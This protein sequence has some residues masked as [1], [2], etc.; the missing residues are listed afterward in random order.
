MATEAQLTAAFKLAGFSRGRPSADNQRD[1]LVPNNDQVLAELFTDDVLRGLQVRSGEPRE[2]VENGGESTAVGGTESLAAT[3]IEATLTAG[4]TT[5]GRPFDLESID[6]G[7]LISA[8][9]TVDNAQIAMRRRISELRQQVRILGGNL[10]PDLVVAGPTGPA[11]PQGPP[12]PMGMAGGLTAVATDESLSGDGT[13]GDPL[14]VVSA[15]SGGGG[16]TTLPLED[17]YDLA[18]PD[19]PLNSRV[20][21]IERATQ[22]VQ[23]SP[24]LQ[25]DDTTL[26]DTGA[27]SGIEDWRNDDLQDI[28]P[29]AGVSGLR[30]IVTGVAYDRTQD[31]YIGST[32]TSI[33]ALWVDGVRYGN[34]EFGFRTADGGNSLNDSP[35]VGVRNVPS[36]SNTITFNVEYR[37][38]VDTP[39]TYWLYSRS[40][41]GPTEEVE[42]YTNRSYPVVTPDVNAVST[43]V[44][45]LEEVIGDVAFTVGTPFADAPASS[46]FLNPDGWGI[47]YSA[48][49]TADEYVTNVARI[50]QLSNQ[51]LLLR[52]PRGYPATAARIHRTNPLTG[53]SQGFYPQSGQSWTRHRR[54]THYDFYVI[55]VDSSGNDARFVLPAG[56]YQL[57][58]APVTRNVS[59][60]PPVPT[61]ATRG[62]Y[63]AQATDGENYALVDAPSGGGGGTGPAGPQGPA[64][65]AGMDGANGIG[66]V[67]EELGT[68]EVTTTDVYP[69]GETYGEPPE[70]TEWILVENDFTGETHQYQ[71]NKVT[72]S[73]RTVA[74]WR[75][76][77]ASGGTIGT[78]GAEHIVWRD[79]DD[80]LLVSRASATEPDTGNITVYTSTGNPPTSNGGG[81]GG[82]GLSWTLLGTADFTS[83]PLGE[84]TY[85][86]I[87]G[88]PTNATFVLVEIER[89]GTTRQGLTSMFVWASISSGT[90]ESFFTF[91][92]P[93]NG[94]RAVMSLRKRTGAVVRVYANTNADNAVVNVYTSP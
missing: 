61:Q 15:P 68:M 87:S 67:W 75:S 89:V 56:S 8:Y 59:R 54:T 80:N 22:E 90:L 38:G 37:G 14:S 19:D 29:V 70:G 63:L 43:R 3:I 18:D 65:P 27:I 53:A 46:N 13:A 28:S 41:P 51:L 94:T 58:L 48:T 24:G 25:R 57:Q 42:V 76:S 72:N 49:R 50:S 66:F 26:Q 85:R 44:E 77:T 60:I 62:Q 52:A 93:T 92:N 17:Q 10:T 64:G 21:V 16:G 34:V 2:T 88:V 84:G 4:Y 9:A 79:N 11:G 30:H 55:T 20:V 74:L 71:W 12:G 39:A 32:D 1:F 82:G 31:F 86:S 78:V 35:L 83:D 81:G 6:S 36:L 7:G 40:T 33:V 73:T 69:T 47:D 91:N 45:H 5:E 23:T